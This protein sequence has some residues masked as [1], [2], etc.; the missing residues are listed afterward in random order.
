[1]EK[2]VYDALQLNML[3]VFEIE[4]AFC[5]GDEGAWTELAALPRH[6]MIKRRR[7]QLGLSFWDL[8]T[9]LGYASWFKTSRDDHAVQSYMK[10]MGSL[11]DTPDAVDDFVFMEVVDLAAVLEIPLQLLLGVKCSKCGR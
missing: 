9:R 8:P 11:E 2:K 7:E 5:R 10:R 4:C 6:Q 1:M 3:D